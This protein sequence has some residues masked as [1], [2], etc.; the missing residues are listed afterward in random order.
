MKLTKVLSKN[1]RYPC[2][3]LSL[4][5]QLEIATLLR[6]SGRSAES[7]DKFAELHSKLLAIGNKNSKS[8]RDT[9]LLLEYGNVQLKKLSL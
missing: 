7:M 5:I 4:L 9:E 3:F 2:W 8:R 6:L 1:R